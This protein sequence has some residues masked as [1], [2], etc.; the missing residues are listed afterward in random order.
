MKFFYTYH[1]SID[2]GNGL[3]DYVHSPGRKLTALEIWRVAEHNRLQG[4]Y[5]K[6]LGIEE[7]V[8]TITKIE[9]PKE[10]KDGNEKLNES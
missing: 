10:R 9:K 8:L 3:Y 7:H 6:V 5:Q 1:I 2:T 4:N